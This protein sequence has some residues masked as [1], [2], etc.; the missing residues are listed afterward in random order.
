MHR[1]VGVDGGKIA[2]NLL[3]Q[4]TNSF[5]ARPQSERFKEMAREIRADGGVT[6]NS[7][8][9]FSLSF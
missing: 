4:A 6:Q 7:Q 8:E 5:A 1:L 3:R 9:T 2:A